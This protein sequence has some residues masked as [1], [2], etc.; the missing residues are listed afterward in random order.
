MFN[1]GDPVIKLKY[2][3]SCVTFYVSHDLMQHHASQEK[4]KN[5]RETFFSLS[6]AC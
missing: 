2:A 4:Q 6:L 1:L 3:V 5:I